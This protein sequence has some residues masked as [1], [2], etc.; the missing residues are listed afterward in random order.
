EIRR[1]SVPFH[2]MPVSFGRRPTLPARITCVIFSCVKRSSSG[3]KSSSLTVVCGMPEKSASAASPWRTATN[4]LLPRSAS[5]RATA[6]GSAPPPAMMAT[7]PSGI[8]LICLSSSVDVIMGIIAVTQC[9]YHEMPLAATG[10]EVED[11][12]DLGDVRKLLADGLGVFRH[13]AAR[14]E[15]HAV[16]RAHRLQLRA[17]HAR[18]LQP[19]DVEAVQGCTVTDRHGEGN[20][21]ADDRRAAAQESAAADA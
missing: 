21:V 1:I 14:R 17:G 2:F 18:A 7:R 10:H 19:D 6:T 3:P 5:V 13:R 8:C 15:Q 12:D 11:L 20:D 16:S 4:G 9:R